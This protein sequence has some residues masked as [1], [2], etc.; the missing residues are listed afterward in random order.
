MGDK[1]KKKLSKPVS[2]GSGRLMSTGVGIFI[3]ASAMVLVFSYVP[4][5]HNVALGIQAKVLEKKD[6]Y[7]AR[8][9]YQTLYYEGSPNALEGII[10]CTSELEDW[11]TAVGFIEDAQYYH[12]DDK[13]Y[14]DILDKYRPL[15]PQANL[16]SGTYTEVQTI[17]IDDSQDTDVYYSFNGSET[18]RYNSDEWHLNQKQEYRLEC[19][20]VNQ[21]ELQSDVQQYVYTMEIPVPAKVVSSL[22]DG[23]YT[24]PQV[25]ELSAED[26]TTIYYTLD[27]SDPDTNS[28]RYEDKLETHQGKNVIKAVAYNKIGTR[29]EMYEGIIDLELPVP[30]N[31]R[32]SVGSGRYSDVFSV[33][34]IQPDG[35]QVYYSLDGSDPQ[36]LYTGAISIPKGTTVLTAIAENEYH[37]KSD[38]VSEKYTVQYDRYIMERGETGSTVLYDGKEYINQRGILSRFDED[39]SNREVLVEGIEKNSDIVEYN[40]DIYYTNNNRLYRLNVQT[41]DAEKVSDVSISQR[42]VIYNGKIYFLQDSG[43][44]CMN[45]DGSGLEMFFQSAEETVEHACNAENGI[46]YIAIIS[47]DQK[48]EKRTIALDLETGNYSDIG[49]NLIKYNHGDSYQIS[50]RIVNGNSVIQVNDQVIKE[51]RRASYNTPAKGLF[52]SSVD[53]E[54]IYGYSPIAVVHNKIY[55]R[56]LRHQTDTVTNW[57]GGK[58]MSY[59]TNYSWLVYDTATG[60]SSSLPVNTEIVYFT[61]SMIM[62]ENGNKFEVIN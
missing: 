29:G 14:M 13:R 1:V 56:E 24:T 22:P 54:I 26:D 37:Q 20:S 7:E 51:E 3:I 12:S 2:A 61:D 35:A 18:A 43:V 48:Q 41:L 21:L 25:V 52:D 39:L 28:L 50:Q 32:M 9:I 5:C 15:A 53:T 47:G 16:E 57:L 62:D 10:R 34:L 46:W 23:V 45:L 11:N 40:G 6:P 42:F 60:N 36:I 59:Q 58:Q 49:D 44:A 8:Y 4:A 38:I 33:E 30:E 27:G 19:Y 31:V 17:R 55:I